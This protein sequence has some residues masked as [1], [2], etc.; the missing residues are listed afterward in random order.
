M[1]NTMVT[2]NNQNECKAEI[3]HIL[4]DCFPDR[5]SYDFIY[6]WSMYRRKEHLTVRLYT[7]ECL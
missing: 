6:S 7:T 3:I 5:R 2:E 1:N 4:K